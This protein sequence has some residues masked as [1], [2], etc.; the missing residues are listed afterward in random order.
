MKVEA[1]V[2]RVIA[3]AGRPECSF[4]ALWDVAG[5][6]DESLRLAAS[7]LGTW[8]MVPRASIH[9]LDIIDVHECT[10]GAFHRV[11]ATLK[12]EHRSIAAQFRASMVSP[13]ALLQANA[14]AQPGNVTNTRLNKGWLVFALDVH[15]NA[16]ALTYVPD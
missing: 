12:T 10:E 4:I 3:A 1:D 7:C 2:A 9:S 11:R 6:D 15:G 8:S 5:S 13:K 16:I 14:L